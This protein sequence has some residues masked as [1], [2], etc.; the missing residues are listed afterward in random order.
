MLEVWGRKNSSNVMSVMWTIGELD[1]DHV[2]HNVGGT[3]GGASE[4]SYSELNPNRTVP[5]IRDNDM[6]MWESNAIVRYLAATYGQGSLW[7]DNPG[8]R[9]QSD[10]WMEW[11]KTTL[12]PTFMPV[13]FN[14]IRLPPEQYDQQK[15]D[16]ALAATSKVIVVLERHLENNLF[17]AG[18]ELTMGDIPLGPLAYRFF[19]LE[20][21]R[22]SVPNIKAWYE[23]ICSRPAYKQH[24]MLPFGRNLEEWIALEKASA[25]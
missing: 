7:P 5:T 6:V 1:L 12:Y 22:P 13:F 14:I 20:I 16:V 19:N 17:V 2:R 24:A 10:Q 15:I 9:A 25:N 18:R 3:F 8:V 4:S 21:A 11:T 23:R